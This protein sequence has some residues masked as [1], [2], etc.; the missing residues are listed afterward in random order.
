MVDS[1]TPRQFAYKM[2]ENV[3]EALGNPKVLYGRTPTRDAQ[4]IR[5]AEGLA[6]ALKII[7]N[8]DEL[9]DIHFRQQ[10]QDSKE[11]PF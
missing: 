10:L 7:K 4:D 6:T 1:L 3:S 5:M 8:A 2:I 11:L 9:D